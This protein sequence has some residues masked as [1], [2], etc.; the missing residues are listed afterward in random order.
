MSLLVCEE[1]TV[2]LYQWSRGHDIREAQRMVLYFRCRDSACFPLRLLLLL[3]PV[4]ARL[5]LSFSLFPFSLTFFLSSS[6]PRLS[7]VCG[8]SLAPVTRYS[9]LA[10][11]MPVQRFST[12]RRVPVPPSLLLSVSS[13]ALLHN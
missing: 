11:E 13:H 6:V 7:I 4:D 10:C 3:L 1:Q 9:S 8:V 12:E 2:S 5:P